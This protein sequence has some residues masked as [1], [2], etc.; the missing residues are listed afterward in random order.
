MSAPSL[1]GHFRQSLAEVHA[2]VVDDSPD[3][4]ETIVELLHMF[5]IE[6]TEQASD[7]KGALSV[8]AANEV[9]LILTDLEMPPGM[10]GLELI[11][12]VRASVRLHDLPIIMM[13]GRGDLASEARHLGVNEFLAKPVDFE[14]LERAIKRLTVEGAAAYQDCLPGRNGPSGVN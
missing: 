2:L 10:N 5:G 6:H 4:R 14:K 9:D 1:S 11:K 13:S 3:T 8:L 7:G 12:Q